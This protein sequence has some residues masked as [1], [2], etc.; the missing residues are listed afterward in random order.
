M[1]GHLLLQVFVK[2]LFLQ[3][4]KWL[5]VQRVSAFNMGT[6]VFLYMVVASIFFLEAIMALFNC[7]NDTNMTMFHDP[8]LRKEGTNLEGNGQTY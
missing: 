4:H 2:S 1:F 6:T 7:S 3:Q 5:L 8:S